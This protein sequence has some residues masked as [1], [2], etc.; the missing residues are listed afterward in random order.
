MC[1]NFLLLLY[2]IHL[3]MYVINTIYNVNVP[4]IKCQSWFALVFNVSKM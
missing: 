1:P 2:I 3:F 4:R